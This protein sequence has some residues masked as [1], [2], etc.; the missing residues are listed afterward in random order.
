[1]ET[2]RQRLFAVRNDMFVFWADAGLPFDSPAYASLRKI[3]NRSIRYAHVIAPSRCWLPYLAHCR[4]K[5]SRGFQPPDYFGSFHDALESIDDKDI[6]DALREYHD[7]VISVLSKLYF[8]GSFSGWFSLAAFFM[9]AIAKSIVS[10]S[11]R[12]TSSI[13]IN[14]TSSVS[15][16]AYNIALAAESY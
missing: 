6:A 1:V 5:K 2:A 16:N 7:N 14:R 10:G 13:L 9:W 12:K 11:I 8:L 3:M 15:A 4:L